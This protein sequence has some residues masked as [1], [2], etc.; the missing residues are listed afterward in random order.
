MSKKPKQCRR[1]T[2]AEKK[3]VWNTKTEQNAGVGWSA[4]GNGEPRSKYP[5]NRERDTTL[6]VDKEF[7]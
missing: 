6:T 5:P 2:P 1:L 3:A 7:K 4:I